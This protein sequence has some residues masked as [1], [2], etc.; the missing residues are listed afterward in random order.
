VF[1]AKENSIGS[2]IDNLNSLPA[3]VSAIF[4]MVSNNNYL[5]ADP[6]SEEEQTEEKKQR[7]GFGVREWFRAEADGVSVLYIQPRG[8]T[9]IVPPDGRSE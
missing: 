9:W 2:D 8:T 3:G 1:N 4:V 7:A 6:L 5:F